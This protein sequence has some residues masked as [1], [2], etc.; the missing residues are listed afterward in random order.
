[1]RTWS[2]YS[3]EANVL[4]EL[5]SRDAVSYLQY[6]QTREEL[7]AEHLTWAS[8]LKFMHDHRSSADLKNKALTMVITSIDSQY[9]GASGFRVG[10]ITDLV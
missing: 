8:V 3:V 6:L 7:Y 1:M 4:R 2:L 5:T 9:Y 10:S